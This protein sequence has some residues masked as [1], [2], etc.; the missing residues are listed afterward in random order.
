MR[1]RRILPVLTL[2]TAVAG[3][4]AALV[5]TAADAASPASHG[6][7]AHCVFT[8][9]PDN[10]AAKPVHPPKSK[11]RAHGTVDVRIFTN[12]GEVRIRMDRRNAPCA[13]E[14]FVSLTRQKFY[15]HTQC[16]RLTNSARLGVLQCGDIY[17]AEK[18]GP[19]YKFKDELTGKETYPRG[20]V[21]MGNWGPDTNGSQ[22]FIVHTHANIPPA[23]TVLG[24]VTR[25]MNVLDEI[26]A[27]GII[28]QNGPQDGL[29]KHPVKIYKV[30][31]HG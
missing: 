30:S 21:A 10:P 13:V 24:K 26:A 25:G 29:P 14:N 5:P 8:P 27:G 9:T 6:R 31:A 2:A 23:Y 7:S 19:G 1:T 4:G 20:T 12:H 18:G 16:W 17:A 11:A 28:P 15:N 22:F 3:A